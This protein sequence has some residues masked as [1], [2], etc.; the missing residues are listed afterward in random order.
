LAVGLN[1]RRAWQPR[2]MLMLSE[3]LA[4]AYAPPTWITMTRVRLGTLPPSPASSPDEE[5]ERRMMMVKNRWVDAVAISQWDLHVIEAAIRADLG[6]PSKLELYTRLVKL[7]PDL[8]PFLNRP[9]KG[10]YVFAI[11]DPVVTLKMRELG[12]KVVQYRPTWLPDYLK[13]LTPRERQAP[14]T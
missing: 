6:D 4:K 14:K 2:E 1:E 13:L 12:F 7:T 10:V 11:E 5:A 8:Q 9:I 3:Y